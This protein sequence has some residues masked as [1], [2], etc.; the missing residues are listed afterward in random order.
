MEFF[1]MLTNAADW[2]EATI[3]NGFLPLIFEP[4]RNFL[5][6]MG[7]VGPILEAFF[8]LFGYLGNLA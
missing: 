7:E 6:W 4:F 3:I 8:S 2:I 5:I 1:A